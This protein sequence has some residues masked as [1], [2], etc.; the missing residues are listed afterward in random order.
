M[1]TRPLHRRAI[2]LQAALCCCAVASCAPLSDAAELD[3]RVAAQNRYSARLL[4]SINAYRVKH[5]VTELSPAPNLDVLAQEHSKH[6]A[7]VGQLSHEGFRERGMRSDSPVCVENVGWNYANPEAQLKAWIESPGH[8]KNM[9]DPKVTKAGVG[10]L[11][12]YVTFI[13]CQ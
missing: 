10:E 13:A 1:D 12:A 11:N 7:Q 9:L 6:M 8:N 3:Q 4:V 5:G 2:S